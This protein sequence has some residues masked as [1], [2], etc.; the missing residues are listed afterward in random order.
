MRVKYGHQEGSYVTDPYHPRLAALTGIL[1]FLREFAQDATMTETAA[2]LGIS[3]PALS[4]AMARYQ[5]ELSLRLIERH[6]R[7]IQLTSEGHALAEAATQALAIFEPALAD[8]LDTSRSRPLRLGALRSISGELAPLIAGS[9]PD[10]RAHIVEGSSPDLLSALRSSQI[11]AAILGPKPDSPDF[12]WSFLRQQPFVLVV[13]RNHPLAV[14]HVIELR[15]LAHEK[16]VAMAP[17]YTARSLADELCAEADIDPDIIIESD[18]SNTLRTY[19]AAGV[20]LCILPEA[21]VSPDPNIVCLQIRRADST[22]AS[23]EIGLVRLA[24]SPLPIHM[25]AA[26]RRLTNLIRT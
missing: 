18:N 7:R 13:P 15:E 4:R 2:R 22:L 11:D 21:M 17:S 26:L 12:T 3:Q 5:Q 25:Q 8:V 23:R 9:S 10:M 24:G 16:F 1:P 14:Q 20:G 19:V 6:G